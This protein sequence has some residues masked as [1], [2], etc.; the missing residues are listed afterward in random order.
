MLASPTGRL[1]PLDGWTIEP[2]WDGIRVI[3]D[4]SPAGVRL[5]S[6]N[7]IDKAR[8]FPEVVR[9]LATLST[10]AGSMTLDGELVAIDRAGAPLRF[11]ALQNRH[12]GASGGARGVRTAFV[13]FDILALGDVDL[14]RQPWTERRK[15]LERLLRRS[16][17]ALVRLSSSARCGTAAAGRMLAAATRDGWEGLI[18]KHTAAPY[19]SGRRSPLWRKLKL[20]HEQEFVIG[21]YTLPTVGA[22]RDHFGALLVGYY[23]DE[24][25]LHYAGKV[26]T[27]YTHATL[28]TLGPRLAALGRQ[29]SPFADAPPKRETMVWVKPTLVAQIRY[30]EMT[31]GGLLRQ[32]AF[33]GLRDDK[34]ARDVRLEADATQ[35]QV[36]D[37]LARCAL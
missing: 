34:R 30:N 8:E 27:G 22:A 20:E 28:A 6:R 10:R 26:G 14:R 21:G 11:Q 18:L 31:E 13:A 35:H 37:L 32:P 19:L 36:L 4:V 16:A 24:G 12:V 3:A 7:G 29:S 33:L 5:W 9:A 1:P 25:A 23:D 2:K 15:R 17:R